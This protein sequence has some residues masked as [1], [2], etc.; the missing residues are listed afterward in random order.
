MPGTSGKPRPNSGTVPVDPPVTIHTDPSPSPRPIPS[1]RVPVTT[2]KF[3]MTAPAPSGLRAVRAFPNLRFSRPVFMTSSFDNTGRLFVVEQ[4]G[5]ILVLPSRD[6][7]ATASVFLDITSVVLGPDTRGGNEEGL[8]GLAFDPNY[9]TNGTFYVY[10]SISRPN[11]RP[12]RATLVARYKVSDSDP[13]RADPTSRKVL[14]EVPDPYSN[15]NGG[16][17]AFGPDGMLYVGIGDGGSGGD[18]ENNSQNKSV[19]LGKILRIDVRPDSRTGAEYTIPSDN[20]FVGEAG[21]RPEIWAYGLRNPW[22]FS[23]DRG[24]GA[25]WLADVGQNA[26]EEVNIIEKG[27]NYGWRILEGNANYT[28]PQQ[29]PASQFAAPLHV[30]AHNSTGGWCITG[31]YVYRGSAIAGMRGTYLFGDYVSGT[32]WGLRRGE[33][34]SVSPA[35]VLS[36]VEELASFAEDDA[37]EVYALSFNGGDGAIYRFEENSAT[38][39][40]PFPSK[41]SETGVFKDLA[42]LEVNAGI[43]PY[44]VNM[45]LWSDGAEKRRWIALP[46]EEKMTFNETESWAFPKGTVLVKHFEIETGGGA[47]SSTMRRLETRVML[48]EQAGWAG[49]TYKWNA[50]QTDADLLPGGLTET[51]VVNGQ[52]RKWAYPSRNDCLTCHNAANGRVLGVTTAQVNRDEQLRDWSAI[53]LFSGRLADSTS[54]ERLPQI[55]DLDISLGLRARS[56]LAVNCST[57]HRP[58]GPAPSGIDVRYT[59]PLAET[60]LIGVPAGEGNLGL[61]NPFRVKPGDKENSV[62]FLRMQTL[63]EHRMPKLGSSVVHEDGLKLIGDWISSGAQ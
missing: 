18:P 12:S 38:P 63:G 9:K 29:L 33:D 14:F 19:L 59:T 1:V 42:T 53:G 21:T 25:L 35:T 58:F 13:N 41:L 43:L 45:P 15:H 30:Y 47:G 62:L 34:G 26:W 60:N 51:I 24:T 46:G 2:L 17:I 49:Y 39:T 56:Y 44:N 61:P 52:T 40:Q 6:E 37:G 7:N 11:A 22:R 27:K 10:H 5:K 57:C 4:G 23:F 50:Q 28:N 8:L 20:P 16:M 36:K 32:I 48:H 55:H 54:Y 31:G 3:P